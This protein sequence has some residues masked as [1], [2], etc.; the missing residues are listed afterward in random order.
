[1]IGKFLENSFKIYFFHGLNSTN[2]AFWG[3]KTHHIF[4]VTKLAKNWKNGTNS[5]KFSHNAKLYPKEKG[6]RMHHSIGEWEEISLHPQNRNQ[7]T[8]SNIQM[9]LLK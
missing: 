3:S 1:M 6:S 2:C 9:Q 5:T 4:Y 8:S 7:N